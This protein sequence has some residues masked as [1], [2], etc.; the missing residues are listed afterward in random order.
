MIG[1]IADSGMGGSVQ[2]SSHLEKLY[3]LPNSFWLVADEF[4]SAAAHLSLA[5]MTANLREKLEFKLGSAVLPA[6]SL[7]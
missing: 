7:F 6:S 1:E 4:M 2:E 3:S 5:L